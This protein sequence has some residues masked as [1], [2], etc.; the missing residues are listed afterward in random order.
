VKVW[1]DPSFKLTCDG[2]P[3]NLKR[4]TKQ[5]SCDVKEEGNRRRSQGYWR[6]SGH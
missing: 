3:L 5:E 2:M 1:P 6:K 4:Q